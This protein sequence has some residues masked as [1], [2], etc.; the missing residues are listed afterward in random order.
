MRQNEYLW[1]KE[2]QGSRLNRSVRLVFANDKLNVAQGKDLTPKRFENIVGKGENACYQ[3]FLP[4]PQCFR[5][6]FCSALFKRGKVRY[7]LK[8]FFPTT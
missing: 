4:F 6:G 7:R 5:Q 1:S 3:H 2:L 8:F